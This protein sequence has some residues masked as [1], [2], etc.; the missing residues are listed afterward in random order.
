MQDSCG[1]PLEAA[2]AG[3]WKPVQPFLRVSGWVGVRQNGGAM[4]ELPRRRCFP[5]GAAAAAAD[6]AG[7][8]GPGLGEAEDAGLEVT[9]A[10][11]ALDLLLPA[12]AATRGG[13]QLERE[14]M[15]RMARAQARSGRLIEGGGEA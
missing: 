1:P 7:V 6:A 13:A 5:P 8:A 12:A 4:L 11:W 14:A 9:V 15:R 10:G 2:T 3:A